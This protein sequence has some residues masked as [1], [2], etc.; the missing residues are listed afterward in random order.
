MITQVAGF[1]WPKYIEVNEARCSIVT[2]NSLTQG[3]QV[4]LL[5][6][7][8][9]SH[10]VEICFAHTS[11]KWRNNSKGNTGVTVI[12]IG[13]S[14]IGAIQEK[15]LYGN[16]FLIRT[17]VIS[18]YLTTGLNLI[19]KKEVPLSSLPPMPKGNM[20]Y[21]GGILFFQKKKK[22]NS[23]MNFKLLKIHKKLWF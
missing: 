13:L 18:P 14:K 9:F 22:T 17:D 19:V 3:E 20:P 4:E 1:I 8:V 21:D 16:E 6:P 7:K 15:K 2:T 10:Q 11:F 12:I 23:L 5:W